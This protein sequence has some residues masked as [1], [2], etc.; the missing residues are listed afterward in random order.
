MK[1]INF[2]VY[3]IWFQV[4]YIVALLRKDPIDNINYIAIII[5]YTT[6]TKC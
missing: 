6:S 1:N 3:V 5:H 4:K 2:V